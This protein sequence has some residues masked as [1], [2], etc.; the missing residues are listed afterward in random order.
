MANS[1][2][3]GAQLLILCAGTVRRGLDGRRVGVA[4]ERERR[5]VLEQG[6]PEAADRFFRLLLIRRS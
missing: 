3:E 4:K 2:G 5:L 1:F 6:K